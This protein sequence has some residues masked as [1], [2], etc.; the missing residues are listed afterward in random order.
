MALFA[1]AFVDWGAFG[2][3]L[4][5]GLIFGAG[6]VIL[7]GFVLLGVKYVNTSK[8]EGGR[9]VGY[10]L[11]IA[12]GFICL[13]AVVVGIYATTQK[14]TSKKPSSKSKSALKAPVRQ[15]SAPG[16]GAL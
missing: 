8:G 1:S 7:F 11:A 16:R 9:A 2:K 13:A 10:A 15:R 6:A 4:L 12:C 14:P 3:I 5:A